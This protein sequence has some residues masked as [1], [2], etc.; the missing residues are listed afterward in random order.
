MRDLVREQLEENEARVRI[1]IILT[2]TKI[3]H[4]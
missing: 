1:P 4:E 2:S 3:S